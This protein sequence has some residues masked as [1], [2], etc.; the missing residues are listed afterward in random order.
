M[1]Y[2]KRLDIDNIKN[3]RDLGGVPTKDN[4]S[5]KW[6]EFF[7]SACLD[8]VKDTDIKDLK[9]LNISTIIDLR[10]ENEIAFESESHKNIK[11]NFDYHHISLSP[12]KEFRK[13][14]IDKIISGELSVGQSYRNLIDHY[15]AVRKIVEVLANAEGSALFHCQEGKDRTGIV[16]MIIMGLADVSR[17]DIIADYETS[18]AHLGYIEKF[19]EDEPLSIFRITNPYNMK[20]AYDY[21][22]RK[23]GSFEAY[24]QHA[25]V[26]QK[27]ID[28]LRR[29]IRD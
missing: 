22:I 2:L 12:D 18:S 14:E 19:D 5:T 7:R 29:R 6:H 27:D 23:Y 25:K 26:D 16:S 1:R 3:A 20:E 28:A 24:L 17:G 8:D 4:R 15:E 13:E 11:E 10:R 21:V 9:D